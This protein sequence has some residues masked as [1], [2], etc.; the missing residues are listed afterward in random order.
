MLYRIYN[1]IMVL[2]NSLG[3]TPERRKTARD[4][5]ADGVRDAI[6][7]GALEGGEP[8]RQDELAAHFRVSSIPVREALRQLEA[9][10]LVVIHAHRGAVVSELSF[11]GVREIV[12]IRVVLETLA[13]QRAIPQMTEE[14]LGRAERMADAIDHEKNIVARWGEL[15]WEFHAALYAPAN[16][17]N[18]TA[19]I[20]AQHIKFDRYIRAYHGSSEYKEYKDQAQRE[21]RQLI[22]ICRQGDIAAAS[23]LMPKH[24]E[25]LGDMLIAYFEERSNKSSRA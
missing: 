24:I 12:E 11:E 25:A 10:G 2:N 6:L 22:E 18:L 13:I 15:N 7:Q 9:E 17:P 1:S 23:E 14:D 4:L 8:L 19:L 5:V 21:H 20:K 3:I 16:R